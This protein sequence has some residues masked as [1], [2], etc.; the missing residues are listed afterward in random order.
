[1]KRA[2]KR[3]AAL[4][5]ALAL[6]IPAAA[7]QEA[8]PQAD[9]AQVLYELGLF[10][11][12][13]TKADGSPEFSPDRPASRAEAL[14]MLIRLL[15]QERDAL[16]C[17]QA[18]PFT[19]VPPWADRYVA[20]AYHQG[21][22]RG[23][24]GGLFGG[25]QEASADMYLTFVLRALGYDDSAADSAYTYA[26]A[27]SYGREL[28]LVQE[29]YAQGPF[30]RGDVAQVSLR[31]LSQPE[32]GSDTPLIQ[33][34]VLS[35]AV[36]IGAARRQGFSVP[37]SL[38][39]GQTLRVPTS[40]LRDWESLY[41]PCYYVSA[42]DLLAVLPDAWIVT[43]PD[44]STNSWAVEHNPL[45]AEHPVLYGSLVAQTEIGI[46]PRTMELPQLELLAYCDQEDAYDWEAGAWNMTETEP[47]PLAV[48]YVL[49]K[50]LNAIAI[51]RPGR[52][53]QGLQDSITLERVYIET[54][55][56]LA[57]LH[58]QLEDSLATANSVEVRVDWD[59]PQGP[60]DDGGGMAHTYPV[61]VNGKEIT[62]DYYLEDFVEERTHDFGDGPVEICTLDSAL[63]ERQA[64]MLVCPDTVQRE[65][66]APV[67]AYLSDEE[68]SYYGQVW[69]GSGRLIQSHFGVRYYEWLLNDP[70]YLILVIVRD[71]DG[72]VVGY[73]TK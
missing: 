8:G 56:T 54:A 66:K 7:A 49:D 59:D 9:P 55:P 60:W 17:T 47:N 67:P 19:D 62:Q 40:G 44:P 61:Y 26:T 32:K 30:L 12:T 18:H 35:G 5:L 15:G 39:E 58:Q 25:A 57:K 53:A 45:L 46:A 38:V 63:R 10:K 71:K 48:Q 70:N 29:D 50:E 3:L 16:A 64:Y 41:G 68:R 52:T 23:V 22:T 73:A 14:V 4:G 1:M 13:G 21:L 42:A 36:G 43:E 27:V 33:A 72:N 51:Y 65:G 37:A 28:G 11:G 6:C 2:I 31:A 20:Y 24:G 34:L 69:D